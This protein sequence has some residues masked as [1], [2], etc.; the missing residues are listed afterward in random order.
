MLDKLRIPSRIFGEIVPPG[1]VLGVLRTSVC[2]ETGSPAI[3]VVA[4]AGHDTA[5]AVAAVPTATADYIYL[6]SGR[7]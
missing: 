7:S 2:E 6:S 5:A 3:P 1:T 4:S